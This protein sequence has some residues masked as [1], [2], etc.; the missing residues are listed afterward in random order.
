MHSTLLAFHPFTFEKCLFTTLQLCKPLLF[1][2]SRRRLNCTSSPNTVP[3]PW[4]Q[5]LLF[6][7][8]C[9]GFEFAPFDTC[10]FLE[11]WHIG[12]QPRNLWRLFVL[13]LFSVEIFFCRYY[14]HIRDWTLF[15][16]SGMN[17]C[18]AFGGKGGCP[19]LEEWVRFGV[20]RIFFFLCSLLYSSGT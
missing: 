4:E 6:I 7:V 5:R 10:F 14:T 2:S 20:Q 3:I 9:G 11:A 16:K 12:C 18:H 1:L 19:I 15:T 13:F 17:V 8:L